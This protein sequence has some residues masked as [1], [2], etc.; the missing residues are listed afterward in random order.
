MYI[1]SSYNTLQL[2]KHHP[3]KLGATDI[4]F[5]VMVTDGRKEG[6]MKYLNPSSSLSKN[7]D[8]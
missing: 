3:C 5:V 4:L 2:C 6:M 8:L 7:Q 1:K